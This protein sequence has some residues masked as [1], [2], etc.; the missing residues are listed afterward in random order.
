LVPQGQSI[1]NREE[2]ITILS[3]LYLPANKY[4]KPILTTFTDQNLRGL[5]YQ[6]MIHPGSVRVLNLSPQIEAIILAKV[7]SSYDAL[8]QIHEDIGNAQKTLI[9]F[10]QD[11]LN[12]ST[13]WRSFFDCSQDEM[14]ALAASA[15]L[16]AP[17]PYW[18]EKGNFH[19]KKIRNSKNLWVLSLAINV[20]IIAVSISLSI[21][22]PP[23][24]T[25]GIYGIIERMVY[26]GSFLGF[27]IW[28][29]RQNL[30]NYRLNE[31]LA[32]DAKERVTM[33]ETYAA[34]KSQGLGREN[35]TTILNALFRPAV[36]GLVDDSGP[37][38]PIEILIKS[39]SEAAMKKT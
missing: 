35:Y 34:L 27:G 18:N 21:L 26:F 31:H 38:M 13:E 2:A 5:V 15:A 12:I 25:T 36:T 32:E 10:Q 14:R 17:K 24:I 33:I 28:W 1:G 4:L 20:M 16:Q 39:L 19:E 9:S 37:S 23:N 22:F 7:F 29:S 11:R 8:D 6:E 3:T 30:K